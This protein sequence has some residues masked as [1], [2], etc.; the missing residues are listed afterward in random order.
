MPEAEQWDQVST[1]DKVT[2]SYDFFTGTEERNLFSDLPSY[3]TICAV[4]F[5][6]GKYVQIHKYMTFTSYV[7]FTH[8]R[9]QRTH[10]ENYG[11]I[12]TE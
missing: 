6:D 11:E 3:V 1:H 4:P 10:K 7:Y 9:R 8:F 2:A 12:K 5:I